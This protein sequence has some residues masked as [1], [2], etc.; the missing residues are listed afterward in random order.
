MIEF[1]T[2]CESASACIEVGTVQDMGDVAFRIGGVT[3]V[4]TRE[5]WEVFLNGAK[6]GR[7]DDI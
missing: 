7:F 2:G 4:A 3:L 5:E 6:E 1:K